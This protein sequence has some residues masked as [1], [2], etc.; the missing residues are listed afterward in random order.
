MCEKKGARE[1]WNPFECLPMVFLLLSAYALLGIV[2]DN[3]NDLIIIWSRRIA[4]VWSGW[5]L[6]T[7][8]LW[9]IKCLIKSLYNGVVAAKRWLSRWKWVIELVDFTTWI[10]TFVLGAVALTIV[11][12]YHWAEGIGGSGWQP[13]VFMVLVFGWLILLIVD[14]HVSYKKKRGS[15]IIGFLVPERAQRKVRSIIKSALS[16]GDGAATP[17]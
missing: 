5:L 12:V 13:W 7:P 17:K 14:V 2:G 1:E 6:L 16:K 8:T 10:V 3:E 9:G 11:L 15:I 4:L